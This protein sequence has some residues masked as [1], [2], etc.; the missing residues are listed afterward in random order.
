ML[1]FFFFFWFLE[2]NWWENL[3]VGFDGQLPSKFPELG[4]ELEL[5]PLPL[6]GLDPPIPVVVRLPG[7]WGKGD[8]NPS[9]KKL[10][11]LSLAKI[12]SSILSFK[13]SSSS[14]L[15]EI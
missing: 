2:D 1:F 8:G 5:P 15:V 12:I 11:L 4:A 9:A 3:G 14:F 7:R 6:P 10:T 13:N